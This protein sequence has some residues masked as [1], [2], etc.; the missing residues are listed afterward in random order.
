MKRRLFNLAAAVSLVLCV[1]ALVMWVWSYKRYR[2]KL[3]TGLLQLRAQTTLAEEAVR[4]AGSFIDQ[5]PKP[6]TAELDRMNELNAQAMRLV[7]EQKRRATALLAGPAY[8]TT[9]KSAG[10]IAAVLPVLWVFR[11]S[12]VR[13]RESRRRA[14]GLC[15]SCGYDLRATPERCPECGTPSNGM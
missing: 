2:A 11:R 1:I 7:D 15:I 8:Y 3:E 6:T 14:S 12:F 9:Y 10:M 5:H 13:V 4:N